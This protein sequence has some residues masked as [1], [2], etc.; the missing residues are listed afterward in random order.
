MSLVIG[1]WLLVIGHW[2][3]VRVHK[4]VIQANLIRACCTKPKPLAINT[5]SRRES[6]S[7]SR[8]CETIY[9]HLGFA[10]C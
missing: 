5:W 3:L 9:Q 8:K 6:C 7:S 10:R 2:S 1:H 4:T